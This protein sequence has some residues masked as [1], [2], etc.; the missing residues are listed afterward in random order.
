[1]PHDFSIVTSYFNPLR[2]KS[3]KIN[4]DLFAARIAGAGIPLLVIELAPVGAPFELSDDNEV[5][6]IRGNL[7]IW[8]KERLLNIAISH[9][10]ASC[11]KVAWVD[12]DLIFEDDDWARKASAALDQFSVVQLFSS[13]VRLPR[14]DSEFRGH[15]QDGSGVTEGFAAAFARDPRLAREATYREHGHTGFAWAARRDLLDACALYDACLTGSGDHLMAHAFA[16]TLDSPCIPAM[17][18][19]GHAYAA[20]FDRWAVSVDEACHGNFGC[21]PG[22]VLH[23]WHGSVADRRYYDRNQ[24]FKAFNFDPDR[25]IHRNEMGAW[26]W[27]HAPA[28]MQEW[29][30]NLF[31][32]RNED[33]AAE[34]KVG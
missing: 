12:C 19:S 22:R 21:V 3:K 7:A 6:R 17:I 10:P 1:M 5:V 11:R 26:E 32:S 14:G 30:R 23:L 20:H 4:Y 9:L 13:C 24:Q 18:G 28:V 16:G 33:G 2:Y 31:E 8:Q 34:L 29:A 15:G 25:H 27:N